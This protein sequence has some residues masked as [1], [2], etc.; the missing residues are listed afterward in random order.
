MAAIGLTKGIDMKLAMYVLTA[1][2]AVL[3]STAFAQP[4][5]SRP[6]TI[7]VPYS[8]GGETD[9]IARLFAAR[10]TDEWKRTVIVD[11]RPG[12]ATVIGTGEAARARPDGHTLLLTSFGFTTNRIL[13]PNLPYDPASL[14][15]LTLVST[16][17]NILYV[18]P[19]V[20]GTSLKD[21]I[22]YGK[23][24]PGALLFGSP[25]IASSPHI[26]AELLA[27]KAGITIT[28]VP[29]KGTAPALTD[30]LAG[31][32][33]ALLGVMSLMPHAKAGKLKAIAV[34]NERRLS[35]APE[36]PT[37]AES[38]V[39]FTAASWFGFFV[40]SKTPP[41]VV[42]KI[43]TDIRKTAESAD[44][45][46]KISEMGL[47]TAATSKEE[48]SAFLKSELEKWSAIISERN[49]KAEQ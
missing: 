37:M 8:A 45:R 7:L 48:F 35:R 10:L 40:Q 17:P 29:Y 1:T 46:A 38:G 13:A 20:P 11:N 16:A 49:I 36:L 12:G 14:A 3:S 30:L 24:K 18:H 15:P 44:V 34:A 5:P 27:S 23:T 33:N 39:A 2:L 41:E 32:V 47:E 43:F 28:H 22:Q 21:V 19:S 26:A 31:Q 42:D 25:G 4:Y 6:V 9:A